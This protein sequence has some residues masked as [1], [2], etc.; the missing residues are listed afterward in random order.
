[1]NSVH[2]GGPESSHYFVLGLAVPKV[3]IGAK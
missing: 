3:A 1:M 2:T